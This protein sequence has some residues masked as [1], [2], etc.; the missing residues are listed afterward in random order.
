MNRKASGKAAGLLKIGD[1]AAASGVAVSTIRFYERA[2]LLRPAGR[3]ENNYRYYDEASVQRLRF[4][5]AAQASGFALEDISKLL[6]LSDEPH[7]CCHEVQNLIEHRLADVDRKLRQMRH[8]QRVL[9]RALQACRQG[10]S[11]RVCAVLQRL[12]QPQAGHRPDP[13]R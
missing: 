13:G 1:I 12:Q 11:R 9:A 4:I 7:P 5:R 6:D 8:L 10:E 2:G 3:A